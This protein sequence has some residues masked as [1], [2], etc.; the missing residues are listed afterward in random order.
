MFSKSVTLKT[1]IRYF[2]AAVSGTSIVGLFTGQWLQ[3]AIFCF[4]LSAVSVL[5]GRK[6]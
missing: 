2:L 1:T 5:I 3:G 4:S 6:E